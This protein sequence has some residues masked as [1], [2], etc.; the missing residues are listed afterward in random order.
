[1]LNDIF[2]FVRKKKNLAFEPTVI[3]L[4]SRLFSGFMLVIVVHLFIQEKQY[5][6]IKCSIQES[7]YNL[8]YVTSYCQTRLYHREFGPEEMQRFHAP[9]QDFR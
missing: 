7:V 8:E 3:K 2:A 5:G 1:M 4:H 6:T 9:L